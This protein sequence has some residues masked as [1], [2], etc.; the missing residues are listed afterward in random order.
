MPSQ[1]AARYAK[2]S[3]SVIHEDAPEYIHKYGTLSPYDRS[4]MK[5]IWHTFSHQWIWNI[6]SLGYKQ[7]LE[8]HDCYD[9]PAKDHIL[10]QVQIWDNY[11]K[12][13]RFGKDNFSTFK[14]LWQLEGRSFVIRCIMDTFASL[15]S[16]SVPFIIS[17][18]SN[19]YEDRSIALEVGIY[20]SIALWLVAFI[21]TELDSASLTM[22]G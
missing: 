7:P 8:V 10:T 2:V 13:A 20:L 21:R 1:S 12:K 5:K 4:V 9:V 15:T 18:L 22:H 11:I 16:I 17:A 3:S 6:I 14:C 19:F